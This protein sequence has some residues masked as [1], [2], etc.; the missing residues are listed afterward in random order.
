MYPV[1][2][3]SERNRTWSS[4]IPD[5][6][7]IGPTSAKGTRMYSACPPANPPSMCEYPNNPAGDWPIALRAISAFGFEVLHREKRP[8]LQKK[9]SPHEIVNG[10]TTR[11]PI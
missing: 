8:F 4:G 6:I 5:G 1:G 2:N 10:T 3:I 7:L 11:S 9:H